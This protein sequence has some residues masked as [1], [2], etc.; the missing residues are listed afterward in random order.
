MENVCF[1]HIS[2]IGVCYGVR[3]FRGKRMIF[4][5][6]QGN[7]ETRTISFDFEKTEKCSIEIS[8]FFSEFEILVLMQ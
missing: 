8:V 7:P 2:I 1:E 4:D 5:S 6:S 3:C